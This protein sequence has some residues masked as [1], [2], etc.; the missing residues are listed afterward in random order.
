MISTRGRYALRV[1]LDLAENSDGNYIRLKDVAQRQ[2]ISQKYLES[3]MTALSKS[4]MVEGTQGKGGGYRL[5]RTPEQYR[6]GDILRLTEGSLASVACLKCGAKPCERAGTCQ[7]LP[8]WK[9]LDQ[10]VNGYLDSVTL[11]D[12]LRGRIP[13]LPEQE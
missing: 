6:V 8:L 1:M 7:T 3:I 10:L 12:L 5:N 11:E 13:A 2:E 4:G 9:G